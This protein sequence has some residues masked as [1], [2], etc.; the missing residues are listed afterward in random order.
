MDKLDSGELQFPELNPRAMKIVVKA[1]LST[2]ANVEDLPRLPRK[3]VLE[4]KQRER[5]T[6]R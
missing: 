6:R 5:G 1:G 2:V 4:E 3:E